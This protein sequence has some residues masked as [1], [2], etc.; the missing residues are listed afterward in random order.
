MAGEIT[1]GG[2]GQPEIPALN[3]QPD[4]DADSSLNGRS[5]GA[6]SARAD[7]AAE[8]RTEPMD[9]LLR[10]LAT[11]SNSLGAERVPW[12]PV[13]YELVN[14]TVNEL[15]VMTRCGSRVTL[16]PLASQKF[17]LEDLDEAVLVPAVNAGAVQLNLEWPR[18]YSNNVA[19]YLFWIVGVS[20]LC[21]FFARTVSS[22]TVELVLDALVVIPLLLA[23]IPLCRQIKNDDALLAKLR[24][25]AGRA[26]GLPMRLSE[27][28]YL[29]A[30]TLVVFGIPTVVLYIGSDVSHLWRVSRGNA[31]GAHEATVSLLAISIQWVCIVGA[32][33]LPMV[34]YFVFDRE[35]LRTLRERFERQI[36]RL[37]PS[38]NTMCDV[39]AKYGK[40]LDETYGRHSE[41]R[42]LRGRR[43]PILIAAVVLTLGWSIA[44][45]KTNLNSLSGQ[46][47]SL[48]NLLLPART[49]TTYAF[50]G[51]YFFTLNHV[52]RGYVRGDLRPK[53]YAHISVRIVGAVVLAYVLKSL[54]EGA[55]GNGSSSL[56]LVLA[57]ATGIVPET[58]LV[59]LQ[60]VSRSFAPTKEGRLAL[61]ALARTYEP[62]PLTQL[63]GIDI[64][65][66]ARLQDEG[67]SNVEALAHH[68]L[69][70]LLLRTRIPPSR[71]ID[72]VDQA[73]L[74]IHCSSS[75]AGVDGQPKSTTLSH[76]KGSGIR[77]ATDLENAYTNAATPVARRALL[78][79]VPPSGSHQ[80]L[81][82]IV[83]ALR[84]EDWMPYV[85]HWR[86]Q[87][88]EPAVIPIP[89]A[90][91][92][93]APTNRAA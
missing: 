39:D 27:L 45:L 53:T 34:L 48:D 50:L 16:P 65:D 59:R 79:I 63:E 31:S 58:V 88:A 41:N 4:P 54:V 25:V 93:D 11:R 40:L 22:K 44:L 46:N 81:R 9:E 60:E 36:F 5:V 56:L 13:G 38:V 92:T 32:S 29:A 90:Y 35:K 26:R 68:D 73:I 17:K 52:L 64:Y 43:F 2:S 76:L 69:V 85:R 84:D 20:L 72:W 49:A 77:T 55:G 14:R 61:S 37:D 8:L 10:D 89:E 86:T 33:A 51:A 67:V 28:I 91:L 7:S 83:E 18:R 12:K 1:V 23:L 3:K 47:V 24:W 66:R 57:F 30:V 74:Y 70:D 21:F 82:V 19:L 6:G 80:P 71:L 78:A 15:R 62:D 75:P 87:P 42:L